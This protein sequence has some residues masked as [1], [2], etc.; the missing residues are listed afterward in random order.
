MVYQH[1]EE[2]DY[3]HGRI[4]Q[5]QYT[6]LPMMYLHQYKTHWRDL[7]LFV[8]VKSRRET[9]VGVEESIWYCISSLPYQRY[10]QATSAIRQHWAIENTLHWKLDMG[11]HED[12]CPIYRG[13]AA[14]NLALMRKVVLYLLQKEG[15]STDGIAAKS[16]WLKSVCL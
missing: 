11:L 9:H 8:R 16:P 3:G 4:E 7:S 12:Q 6:V 14:E 10:R 2:N 15:S 5:R 1:C 13:F